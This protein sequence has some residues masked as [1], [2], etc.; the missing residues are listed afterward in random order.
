MA[1]YYCRNRFK[2]PNRMCN[3]HCSITKTA[4]ASI[5]D[6]LTSLTNAATNDIIDT[7]F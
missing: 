5:D 1:V 3:N 7:E 4:L 6:A 2:H